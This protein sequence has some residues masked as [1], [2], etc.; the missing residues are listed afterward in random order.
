[1]DKQ[2]I[3]NY[4]RL[5][6]EMKT[7]LSNLQSPDVTTQQKFDILTKIITDLINQNRS[8]FEF[9]VATLDLINATNTVQE[10]M[11]ES[12]QYLLDSKKSMEE[13]G[14]DLLNN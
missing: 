9:G 13:E 8:Q 2:L 11:N 5:I 10:K 14:P 3:S 7:S 12:I 1:M 6:E 4:D